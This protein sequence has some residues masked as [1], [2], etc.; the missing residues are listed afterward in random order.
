MRSLAC[1][2]CLFA[3]SWGCAS[4]Q[5]DD[6]P[7]PSASDAPGTLIAAYFAAVQDGNR[8]AALACGSKEWAA[9]ESDWRNG[10]TYAFFEE[11]V[12]VASWDLLGLNLE[13]DGVMAARVRAVLTR[14]GEEPDNEGMRFSLKEVDGRWQIVD[15]K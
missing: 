14:A 10:F 13:D 2:L 8:A 11:G 12:G 6:A 4:P 3:L 7:S 15:L 5:V 1:F 9:R